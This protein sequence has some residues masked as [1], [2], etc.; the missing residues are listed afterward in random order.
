MDTL[1]D[2]PSRT[3]TLVLLALGFA[4]LLFVWL[5]FLP[6]EQIMTEGGGYGIVHYELAFTPARVA[7]IHST[8][9]PQAR[10]AALQSLLIDYAF[11]PAYG[12]FF[13]M[14]TLLIARAQSE[15]W[16]NIG[17]WIVVGCFAAAVLD[18]L[19]NAMLL[20]TLQSSS[21]P[22]LPP[23]I[24]GLAATLKFVLLV[25]PVLY[26]AASLIRWNILRLRR[27]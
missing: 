23:L 19:E 6:L 10:H 20:I 27:R 13:G 12:F 3:T 4:G 18:A 16:R 25:I 1:N 14:L 7:A 5:Q 22:S 2:K 17:L 15:R 26:W 24:A 9:G 8:W 11:M 21:I